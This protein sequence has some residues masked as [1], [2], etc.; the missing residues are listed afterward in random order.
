MS[1]QRISFYL[2]RNQIRAGGNKPRPKI[3]INQSIIF[4]FLSLVPITLDYG[5]NLET[6]TEKRTFNHTDTVLLTYSRNRQIEV[7]FRTGLSL[8]SEGVLVEL[9]KV[10][11]RRGWPVQDLSGVY[12]S[13]REDANGA[14]G[15]IPV[16][17][18]T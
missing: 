16:L 5:L 18:H 4:D 10:R 13:L 1:F 15:P 7:W 8:T 3:K 17:H 2:H 9:L 14:I 11:G 12:V 6:M